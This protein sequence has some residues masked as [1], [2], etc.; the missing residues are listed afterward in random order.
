MEI[1]L[2]V[3]LSILGS[4]IA[5]TLLGKLIVYV[6][7]AINKSKNKVDDLI[8]PFLPLLEKLSADGLKKAQLYLE[9]RLKKEQDKKK[10]N[11]G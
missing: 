9:N 10:D 1:L 3:A 11:E 2:I 8:L 4:G 5:L 7:K 6:E